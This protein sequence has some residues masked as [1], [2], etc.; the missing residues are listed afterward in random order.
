VEPSGDSSRN[1]KN[2]NR[3]KHW[4]G[5]RGS[6]SDQ[7]EEQVK[8]SES[9]TAISKALLKAQREITF[10][11]KDATNPHFRSNYADLPAVIDAIKPALNDAGI[12]F[13]QSASHSEH[14]TL[15]LTTRLL[16]ESGEW[17]EDTA[18]L[19]L[20]KND[21]QGYGSAMTYARRYSLAAITGLYQDDDDGN[22]A[23]QTPKSKEAINRIS[24][25]AKHIETK[26]AA[27]DE[28]AAFEAWET[29][30]MDA[31]DSISLWGLL[32]SKTRSTLKHMKT[33][34]EKPVK[35]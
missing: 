26:F 24:K 31:E 5:S 34:S 18:T 22:A 6:K 19:P 10:A 1:W 33:E 14:G 2:R 20:P 8:T 27:G 25:L 29:R 16:H 9:I 32:G 11:T 28:Y 35:A 21:P 12:T 30:D 17:M 15:A 3:P 23:S 7:L 4:R 13:M